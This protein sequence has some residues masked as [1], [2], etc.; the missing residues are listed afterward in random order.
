MNKFALVF[1]GLLTI[2]LGNLPFLTVYGYRVLVA[3]SIVMLVYLLVFMTLLFNGY[4]DEPWMKERK[5][6]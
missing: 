3:G 6:R 2:F 4:F 5:E 1:V